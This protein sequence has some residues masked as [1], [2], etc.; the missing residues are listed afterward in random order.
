MSER[1]V[2]IRVVIATLLFG[3]LVAAFI[4]KVVVVAEENR[5]AI[6]RSEEERCM[7]RRCPVGTRPYLTSARCLCVTEPLR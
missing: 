1:E 6:R 2:A 5:D 4:C 3:G 7:G